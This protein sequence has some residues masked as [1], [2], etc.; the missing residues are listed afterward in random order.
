MGMVPEIGKATPR[1]ETVDLAVI[2]IEETM[3]VLRCV[4]NGGSLNFGP[5][6]WSAFL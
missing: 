2:G 5:F 1:S 4:L 3:D 6:L